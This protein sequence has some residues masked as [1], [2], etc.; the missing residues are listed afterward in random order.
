[1]SAGDL[2]FV[3]FIQV[4]VIIKLVLQKPD[5]IWDHEISSL[6]C[7]WLYPLTLLLRKIVWTHRGKKMFLHLLNQK[8][9]TTVVVTLIVAFLLAMPQQLCACEAICNNF[10]GRRR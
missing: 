9:M 5:K 4:A 3:C 8:K 7:V 6:I 10:L 1:M 2:V